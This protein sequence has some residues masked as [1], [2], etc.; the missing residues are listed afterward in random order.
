MDIRYCRGPIGMNTRESGLAALTC[1]LE[2]VSESAFSAVLAGAGLIG[3][4][5]GIVTIRFIITI[6]TTPGAGRSTTGTPSMGELRLRVVVSGQERRRGLPQPQAGQ[7]MSSIVP[8]ERRGPSTGVDRLPGDMPHLAG[9]AESTLAL[10]ATM[11]MA[12]RQEVIRLAE[13]PA[14]VAEERVVVEGMAAGTTDPSSLNRLRESW[15]C[16]NEEK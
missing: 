4:S 3:D 12:E 6:G 10:S 11:A 15:E 5:I 9:K 14:S 2:L 1:H 7:G 16:R 13:V 8:A